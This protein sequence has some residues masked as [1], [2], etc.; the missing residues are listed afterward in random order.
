[1]PVRG[2]QALV[3]ASAVVV[4]VAGLALGIDWLTSLHSKTT[5]YVVSAPLRRVVLDVASGNAVIVGTQSSTL[6]VRRT[7][8][9]AFGHPARERRSVSGGVLRISSRCPKIVVGSCSVSYELAVPETVTVSVHATEGSVRFTGFRGTASVRTGAG[10]VDV[11][12][13]CG[14]DFAA[15]TG[16]GNVRIAAACSPAH[17]EVFTRSGNATALVPAGRYRVSAGSGKGQPR[18]SGVVRDAAAPFTIDM[19]SGTGKL[20]IGAGL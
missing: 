2:W 5:R 13:Y 20:T 11:E 14:F 16:S 1:M 8:R 7:D 4:V 15:T 12:A 19:H 6:E 18:V 17:L 9:Y 3:G 10:N